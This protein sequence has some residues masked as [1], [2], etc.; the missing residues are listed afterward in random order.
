VDHWLKLSFTLAQATLWADADMR[1]PGRSSIADILAAVSL[2]L[3]AD[4]AALQVVDAADELRVS[5][6]IE[7]VV[8][9][10]GMGTLTRL[11]YGGAPLLQRGPRLSIWRAPTDNDN[12]ASGHQKAAIRWRDAGLDRLAH[13]VQQLEWRQP[14]PQVV[15]VVRALG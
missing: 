10:K 8:F 7:D 9:S 4:M 15:R 1:S 2:P 5:S 14:C 13:H 12:T 11:Q 3:V 6:A